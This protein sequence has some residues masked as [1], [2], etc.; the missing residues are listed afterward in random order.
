MNIFP[1]WI[2]TSYLF[3]PDQRTKNTT[4]HM[5]AGDSYLERKLDVAPDF[6]KTILKRGEIITT[7]DVMHIL[8]LKEG[9]VVEASVSV[10]NCLTVGLCAVRFDSGFGTGLPKVEET[11]F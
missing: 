8:G 1:R 11:H 10:L 4:V 9:D 3:N 5:V 6:P 7:V 2:A